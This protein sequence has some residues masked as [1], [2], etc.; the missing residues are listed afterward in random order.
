M[1]LK[2]KYR[3]YL[4]PQNEICYYTHLLAVPEQQPTARDM[5]SFLKEKGNW[6]IVQ[7]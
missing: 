7:L 2:F 5:E 3:G 1:G 4:H 6:A